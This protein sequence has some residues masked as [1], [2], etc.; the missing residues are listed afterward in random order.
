ML[1]HTIYDFYDGD[2]VTFTG[3][4]PETGEVS[5][6]A[7]Q[8]DTTAEIGPVNVWD[9]IDVL[10]EIAD[11]AENPGSIPEQ[12]E[13]VPTAEDFSEEE[14]DTTSGGLAR[15]CRPRPGFWRTGSVKI[16]SDAEM[17]D[18]GWKIVRAGGDDTVSKGKMEALL[19]Y[20][21]QRR[22]RVIDHVEEL[23]SIIRRRNE[24]IADLR[25]Q[26]EGQPAPTTPRE[27]L[28][29]L[30][31]IAES[32]ERFTPDD[33]TIHEGE[34]YV[35][36]W[37]EGNLVAYPTTLA[38]YT[39]SSRLGSTCYLLDPREPEP[40]WHTAQLIHATAWAGTASARTCRWAFDASGGWLAL[41]GSNMFAYHDD[42]SDVTVLW[43]G[44][45]SRG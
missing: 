27:C 38:S 42:L 36:V 13:D 8:G 3:P 35:C 22:Q 33:G 20:A 31:Q 21:E 7:R 23:Y 16:L 9:L 45:E 15:A 26:I 29:L 39:A 14:W 28:D 37:D 2:Y 44:D 17:A 24:E 6:R 41:D 40:E 43:Q 25:A 34:G 30:R 32:D 10:K 18:R 11:A 4:D 12:G 1:N 5:I 19:E